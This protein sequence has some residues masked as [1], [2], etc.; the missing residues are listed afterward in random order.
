MT[1]AFMALT[2]GPWSTALPRSDFHGPHVFSAATVFYASVPPGRT[3]G[4]EEM[5]GLDGLC[6]PD[7]EKATL[8]QNPQS[9]GASTP[10][11]LFTCVPLCSCMSIFHN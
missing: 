4:S 2:Y 5:K 6:S 9:C 3:C 11:Y 7:A 8:H 10:V 1:P